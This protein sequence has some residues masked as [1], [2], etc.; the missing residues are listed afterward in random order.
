M[1]ATASIIVDKATDVIIVPKKAV[2][3]DEQDNY[4]VNVVSGKKVEP[5]P[6]T[7]GLSDDTNTE[8]ITGLNE[9]ETVSIQ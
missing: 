1:R 8:V 5:R 2:K 7:T 9:G 4:Y 6:V 3:T